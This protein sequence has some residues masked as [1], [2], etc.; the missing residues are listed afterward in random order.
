MIIAPQVLLSM[1]NARRPPPGVRVERLAIVSELQSRFAVTD[2]TAEMTNSGSSG[3]QEVTF[4][5][6]IPDRAYISQFN[7]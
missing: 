1:T 5:I 4:T 3:S 2:V 7:M 6:D